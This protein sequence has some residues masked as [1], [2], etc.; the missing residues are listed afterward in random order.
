[1]LPPSRV[2]GRATVVSHA[3]RAVTT[4]TESQ[5][6]RRSAIAAK[7]YVGNLDAQTTKEELNELFA[8]AGTIIEIFLPIDRDTGQPRGFAF[9]EFSSEAE[10]VD[11]TTRFNGHELN[12]RPLVINP[13]R[14]RPPRPSGGGSRQFR[15]SGPPPGPGG[16]GGDKRNF[17]NKGSRKG[18]RGRKR[19][20]Y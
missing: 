16:F 9:V 3:D 7:L 17:K 18:I 19:S 10:A 11:A 20:L 2:T 12:G 15:S 1:M 5:A 6:G 8:A 14:D 13:A 4:T